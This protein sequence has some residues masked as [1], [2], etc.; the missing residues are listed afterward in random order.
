MS[1]WARPDCQ[2]QSEC[3]PRF[4]CVT[5]A[6]SGQ[7]GTALST[8]GQKYSLDPQTPA[9][10]SFRERKVFQ[11]AR[12]SIMSALKFI[13]VLAGGIVA[14]SL[15][16]I[17]IVNF[18]EARRIA[19]GKA[20]AVSSLTPYTQTQRRRTAQGPKWPPTTSGVERARPLQSIRSRE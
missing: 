11:T 2:K 17:L 1:K 18:V 7:Q 9:A 8:S 6:Q 15:A 19:R 16:A 14:V 13:L 5:V 10:H 12:G 3:D 4:A 20:G